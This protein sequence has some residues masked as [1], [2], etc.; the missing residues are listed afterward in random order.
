MKETGDRIVEEEEEVVFV[1][2]VEMGGG[3]GGAVV[4]AV[5]DEVRGGRGEEVTDTAP[6]LRAE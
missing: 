4:L 1:V 2:A 6:G 3:G 5:M